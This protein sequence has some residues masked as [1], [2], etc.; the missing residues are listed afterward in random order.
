MLAIN[1][2]FSIGYNFY[3]WHNSFIE[4]LSLTTKTR[5]WIWFLQVFTRS[6]K[7]REIDETKQM[8]RWGLKKDSFIWKKKNFPWCYVLQ[9][10]VGHPLAIHT[11]ATL[12]KKILLEAS[13]FI[14]QDV[15][16][17]N[18]KRVFDYLSKVLSP[19]LHPRTHSEY[20]T[21]QWDFENFLNRE[22]NLIC[23]LRGEPAR[24]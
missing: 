6:W 22:R 20:T 8:K 3:L 18:C 10:F 9:Y 12:N 7:M 1:V 4:Y 5:I 21:W 2:S 15:G 11:N 16:E 17:E 19:S 24:K 14:F 23:C 13:L